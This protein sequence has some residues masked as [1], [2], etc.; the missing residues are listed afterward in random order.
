[1]PDHRPPDLLRL[2]PV[3]FYT[4]DEEIDRVVEVLRE[5]LDGGL[6]VAEDGAAASRVP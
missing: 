2:A 3:A 4:L 5:L 1:V 6:E